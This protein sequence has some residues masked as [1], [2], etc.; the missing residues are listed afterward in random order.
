[1][2]GGRIFK[3]VEHEGFIMAMRGMSLGLA[4]AFLCGGAAAMAAEWHVAPS[5]SASGAGTQ[6][7]PWD[8]CY[9]VSGSTY[10]KS[11][12]PGDTIW[13]HAGNYT[14]ASAVGKPYQDGARGISVN[15]VGTAAA[16]IKV[17]AW[18]GD[19]ATVQTLMD[20]G[21]WNADGGQ[22]NY[23]WIIGLE[24]VT[25]GYNP[26]GV[27]GFEIGASYGSYFH[28]G[29]CLGD[30]VINCIV[31]DCGPT[32]GQQSVGHYGGGFG[33]W[34]ATAGLEVHGN[35]VYYNGMDDSDRAHGHGFYMQTAETSANPSIYKNNIV[36]RNFDNGYQ[37][38]GSGST[39]SGA[40]YVH[41]IHNVM[42]N[43]SEISYRGL[44]HG[45]E[46]WASG[47]STFTN[48]QLIGEMT[49]D[50]RTKGGSVVVKQSSNL[51]FTDGIFVCDAPGG[52]F[53][54]GTSNSNPTVSGVTIYGP[55]AANSATFTSAQATI[56]PTRPAAGQK[57]FV[58]KNDY[59]AG[60]GN[61]IIFNWAKSSTVDVDLSPVLSPGDMYEVRDAQNW[62]KGAVS[63]TG[64]TYMG[65]TVN[66]PMTGLTAAA[67]VA[68]SAPQVTS[69][70]HTAPEFAVFVVRKT[71]T[72][73]AIVYGDANGDLVFGMADI[74]QLVD[75]LL[76][77][78]T[79]PAAGTA[80]FAAS[81][82]NGDNQI[83]MADL[84]L[85]VDRLLGRIT[86]FPVEP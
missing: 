56:T 9:A 17:A 14:Y 11:V 59:E 64:G 23:T 73:S 37:I 13:V 53:L 85:M 21:C 68:I 40:D 18:P 50:P 2:A 6:A 8:L 43:T 7:S 71:G 3:P 47:G 35:L 20:M 55:L 54:W 4:L 72:G 31:H 34:Y 76:S 66:F 80:K 65:G 57:I 58:Y 19:R 24:V 27:K 5:G 62:F 30:K 10:N 83:T 45:Q 78:S 39:G 22:P 60:R 32:N 26:L 75:W 25:R 12:K 36:F 67:P 41:M 84:N 77:R 70:T 42:F 52:S 74:N 29:D 86:K 46:I 33:E 61:V 16:P 44:G 63:G 51:T 81:D 38:Y 1:V 69:F 49:Y 82:V 48:P 15:L 79:P 28:P